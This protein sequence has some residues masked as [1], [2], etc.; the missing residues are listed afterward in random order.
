[1]DDDR[2]ATMLNG[3]NSGD[4]NLFSADR[5]H[6]RFN[7]SS[8]STYERCRED[9]LRFVVQR[10]EPWF[11]AWRSPQLLREREDSPL[12]A[13]ARHALQR[14]VDA[15]PERVTRTLKLFGIKN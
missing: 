5:F 2:D 3:P 10:A 6:L 12:D 7:A 9:L 8:G 15:S 4:L 14:G 11:V 1:M 13:I